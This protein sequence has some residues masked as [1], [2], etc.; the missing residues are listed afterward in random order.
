M[1]EM[2]SQVTRYVIRG[3]TPKYLAKYSGFSLQCQLTIRVDHLLKWSIF[4]RPCSKM[5]AKTCKRW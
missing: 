3:A 2:S 1:K 4:A 5:W